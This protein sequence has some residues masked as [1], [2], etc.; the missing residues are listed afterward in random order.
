ME[1]VLILRLIIFK[2]SALQAFPAAIPDFPSVFLLMY[3]HADE[4]VGVHSVPCEL[5][6]AE[7]AVYAF[8]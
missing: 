2:N 6:V 3:F 4:L 1:I 8:L 7:G 5:P